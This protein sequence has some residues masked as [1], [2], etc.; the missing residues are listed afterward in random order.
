MSTWLITG[1]NRGIGLGLASLVLK[2]GDHV[3]AG[4]REPGR[5]E[6]LAAQKDLH[7]D[8]LTILGLDVS[9]KASVAAAAAMSRPLNG[10]LRLSRRYRLVPFLLFRHPHL[11]RVRNLARRADCR[12][13]S[14]NRHG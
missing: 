2:R 5:A 4:V 13:N 3:I 1:A 10:R 14:Q 11:I 8:R 12:R 9:D 6:S 7:G